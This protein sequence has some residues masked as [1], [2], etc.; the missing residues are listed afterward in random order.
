MV[1]QNLTKFAVVM[2]A[3]GI[4]FAIAVIRPSFVDLVQDLT[5]TDLKLKGSPLESETEHVDPKPACNGANLAVC[6]GRLSECEEKLRE[7]EDALATEKEAIKTERVELGAERDRLQEKEATLQR[8]E[9]QLQ[10]LQRFSLAALLLSSLL[11]VPSMV[12]FLV[13]GRRGWQMLGE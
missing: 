1:P 2:V 4:L 8:W 5:G 9:Q 7:T 12:I 6:E 13:L 11:A 10:S 3:F